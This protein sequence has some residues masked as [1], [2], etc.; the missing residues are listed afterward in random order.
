MEAFNLSKINIYSIDELVEYILSGST[1]KEQLHKNG[2]FRLNR[3]LLDKALELRDREDWRNAKEEGTEAAI[4]AYLTIYDKD[5]PQYKGMFVEEAKNT[6][7]VQK[8]KPIEIDVPEMFPDP[9][10]VNI[11]DEISHIVSSLYCHANRRELS[12]TDNSAWLKATS[13]NTIHS[14]EEYLRVYKNNPWGYVGTHVEDAKKKIL[15][16]QEASDWLHASIAKTKDAYDK[17]ISKYEPIKHLLSSNHLDE[18][19]KWLATPTPYPLSKLIKKVSGFVAMCLLACLCIWAYKHLTKPDAPQPLSQD[20]V[21]QIIQ[22]KEDSLKIDLFDGFYLI[23]AKNGQGEEHAVIS[24]MEL[25][26]NTSDQI[27]TGPTSKDEVIADYIASLNGKYNIANK[28]GEI[29]NLP[30]AIQGIDSL[31]LKDAPFI[32]YIDNNGLRRVVALLKD[33]VYYYLGECGSHDGFRQYILANKNGKYGLVDENGT[34]LK[35]FFN[36]KIT[37][38]ANGYYVK[39]KGTNQLY[40]FAGNALDN[41]KP[42]SSSSSSGNSIVIERFHCGKD[43]EEDVFK[44]SGGRIVAS[45]DYIDYYS[46]NGYYKVKGSNGKYGIYNI[47]SRSLI[48]PTIYD[49]VSVYGYTTNMFPVEKDGKWG[50]VKASGTIAIP[51]KFKEALPF[52]VESKLA[53]VKDENAK[54]GYIDMSGKFKIAAQYYGGGTMSSEGAR[55]MKSSSE[56]GYI[57]KSGVLIASWYPYM[58]TKFVLDRI[59]VR[60]GDKLG[61]F[62]NRQNQLVIPYMFDAKF[63][64]VFNENSHLAKVS[65]K[66]VEWYI[67][68]NGAFCYPASSNLK[69][70]EQNIHAQIVAAKEKAEREKSERENKSKEIDD[71]KRNAKNLYINDIR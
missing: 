62:V 59:F 14:Y 70:S 69:P 4:L 33:D 32:E 6:Y 20:E 35:D 27:P 31:C 41:D 39:N 36:E 54:C 64:P 71:R 9:E 38:T 56:Y 10:S 19:K 45:F 25:T 22:A 48:V 26:E 23:P 43:G 40:N 12:S 53:A 50:Y 52:G 7:A 3:P 1:T 24:S 67:N 28:E 44:D 34:I 37:L 55:V 42:V 2:L 66:G 63:E 15:Q 51:F 60:N 65:Y 11:S 61:G 57:T 49:N 8:E 29:L 13:K 58:G 18:A 21:S 68:T 16:L 30:E 17:Y 47:N 5:E 46:A